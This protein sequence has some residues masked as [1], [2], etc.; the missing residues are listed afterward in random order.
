[1][2]KKHKN[3]IAIILPAF[4]EA[5][6]I[7]KTLNKL[8]AELKKDKTNNFTLIVID[9]G[10]TDKTKSIANK[11]AHVVLHH[12]INRG[13]GAALATGLE[14]VRRNKG[15]NYA[16]TFD[17]DGQHNP[18]DIKKAILALKKGSDVVIGSR[19]L[20]S[21]HQFPKFRKLILQASNLITYLFF[22][23]WTTDSQSGFRGFNQK[24]INTIRIRTNKM[25]VS[26][27]FFA[28]IKK[29]HLKFTEIPIKVKYTKYSLSKGQSNSN[30]FLVLI[31]L[32]YKLAK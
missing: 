15:F 23:V 29:N 13:L 1:M 18:K 20:T 3:N 32:I 26:S 19:F 14:Y 16:I 28:E 7:K 25:E 31:K 17:S 27:E 21:N 11:L 4:N 2:K 24:A 8:K 30:S 12:R 6:V 9:D 10:S 5:K 22:H